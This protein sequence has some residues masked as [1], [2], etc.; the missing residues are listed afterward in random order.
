MSRITDFLRT[1]LTR[2][3][4]ATPSAR[5]RDFC[6]S[7]D[8]AKLEQLNIPQGALRIKAAS[9]K[10]GRPEIIR[11][12]LV[13]DDN[14]NIL[15]LYQGLIQGELDDSV[16]VVT[17]N[18]QQPIKDQV[19][20]LAAEQ[21][22]DLIFMD[23]DMPGISGLELGK[24]L[25]DNGYSGYIA[26]NSSAVNAMMIALGIADFANPMKSDPTDF[27]KR[28]FVTSTQPL[29]PAPLV[30]APPPT[31]HPVSTAPGLAISENFPVPIIKEGRPDRIR[32]ILVISTD[33]ATASTLR[34]L[35]PE[36]IVTEIRS[37]SEDVLERIFDE[38]RPPVD[39]L[40]IAGSMPAMDTPILVHLLR[41]PA[42]GFSFA[43]KPSFSGF[44]LIHDL[45]S[46]DGL[47]AL[48]NGADGIIKAGK[49]D[50]F[51]ADA[52][53]LPLPPLGLTRA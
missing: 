29:P 37:N 22:I 35:L 27:L 42:Q 47:R 52:F 16:K 32:E 3:G 49:I 6:T 25:R 30:V 44:I 23:N 9:A 48:K 5:I 53:E 12:I 14:P 4:L 24:L 18:Q 13:V 46:H 8:E 26:A 28:H 2:V 1:T 45:D 33:P 43:K 21:K 36:I 40:I 51:A 10:P 38:S 20:A 15:E 34:S 11:T 19:L 31:V 39:L 7:A 41:D 17:V 50:N